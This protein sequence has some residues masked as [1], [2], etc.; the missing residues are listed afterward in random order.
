VVQ[1]DY[2]DALYHC[3]KRKMRLPTGK[4]LSALFLY[5]NTYNGQAKESHN[6]IAAP[7]NDVRYPGG[8]YG[9]GGGS[10]CWSH[11]FAGKGF[12]KVVDLSNGRVST[13]QNSHRGYVSCVR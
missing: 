10:T 9:W 11:T 6:A 8:V 13:N 12:H 7:G 2:H 5:A 1:Y 3:V 4:E